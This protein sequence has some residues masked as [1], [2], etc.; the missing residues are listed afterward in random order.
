MTASTPE[1]TA[2][3]I[4]AAFDHALI[5]WAEKHCGWHFECFSGEARIWEDVL[6]RVFP[7]T[8]PLDPFGFPILTDDL[9]ARLIA[10]MEGAK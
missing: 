8:L 7:D 5:W 9:R 1:A 3:L 4:A 10:E 6:K 2:A